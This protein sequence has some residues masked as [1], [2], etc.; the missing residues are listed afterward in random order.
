MTIRE[1][2]A[3]ALRLFSLWLLVQ[4]ILNVSSLVMLLASIEHYRDQVIPI[5]V[6][7]LLIGALSLIG[8]LVFCSNFVLV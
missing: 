2:T 7:L 6:G 8:L 1:V 3:I 4:V 5:H